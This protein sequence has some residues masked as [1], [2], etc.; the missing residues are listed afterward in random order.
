[1]YML[2]PF[3]WSIPVRVPDSINT[4]DQRWQT[5]LPLADSW[6]WMPNV[7][8]TFGQHQHVLYEKWKAIPFILL[9]LER[10]ATVGPS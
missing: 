6:R 10:R 5:V 1:M 2:T 9:A 7:G 4:L 3:I 8:P